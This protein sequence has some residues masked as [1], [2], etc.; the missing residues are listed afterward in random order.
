MVTPRLAMQSP[1]NHDQKSNAPLVGVEPG[2]LGYLKAPYRWKED[3][4]SLLKEGAEK[5][6]LKF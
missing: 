6:S 5:V 4:I 1:T 3:P 2:I